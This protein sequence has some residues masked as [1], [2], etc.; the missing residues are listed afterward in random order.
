MQL[1]LSF[2]RQFQQTYPNSHV[3]G[4]IG[5]MLHGYDLKRDL[6]ISDLDIVSDVDYTFDPYYVNN[7]IIES[8]SVEDFATRFIVQHNI[9]SILESIHLH[10]KVEIRIDTFDKFDVVEYDGY[11]YNVSKFI[12]ILIWKT[13]YASKGLRKHISDIYVLTHTEL[14][15]DAEFGKHPHQYETYNESNLIHATD[16]DLPF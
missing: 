6:S 12:D 5:L 2:L 3:G 4:S 16:N 15:I 14:P 1:K 9:E 13:K 7:E 10:T 11:K 8:S